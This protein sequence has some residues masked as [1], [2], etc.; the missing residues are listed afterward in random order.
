[1]QTAIE[2]RN[3]NYVQIV[4]QLKFS[5]KKAQAEAEDYDPHQ[6]GGND[7]EAEDSDNDSNAPDDLAA[8]EPAEVSTLYQVFAA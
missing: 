3:K 1:M 5:R 2:A 6:R 4:R 7:S 8:Y